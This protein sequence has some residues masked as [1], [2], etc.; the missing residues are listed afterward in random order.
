MTIPTS[1]YIVFQRHSHQAHLH[2]DDSDLSRFLK[3]TIPYLE[4]L[5]SLPQNGRFLI[6]NDSSRFFDS[7]SPSWFTPYRFIIPHRF[8]TL[9]LST[10]HCNQGF[11]SIQV[12]F[13]SNPD[14]AYM[15]TY[16]F[17]AFKNQRVS[18]FPSDASF[19]TSLLQASRFKLPSSFFHC[20]FCSSR[21]STSLRNQSIEMAFFSFNLQEPGSPYFKWRELISFDS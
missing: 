15:W 12:P 6:S 3:M 8:I 21:I 17:K 14:V 4:K 19:L 11:D 7:Q 10:H 20:S 18:P 9:L 1:K 5:S 16:S 13:H 2:N